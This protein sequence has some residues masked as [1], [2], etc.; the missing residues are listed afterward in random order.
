M[1]AVSGLGWQLIDASVLVQ[2]S[3]HQPSRSSREH[4]KPHFRNDSFS[5]TMEFAAR[6]LAL[7]S[8]VCCR[9]QDLDAGGSETPRGAPALSQ[10]TAFAA[11]SGDSGTR[12][13][14]RMGGGLWWLLAVPIVLL[15]VL[16]AGVRKFCVSLI[17]LLMIVL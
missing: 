8:L 15:T 12:R 17:V 2:A 3:Q 14:W 7:R 10:L 5:K 4:S 6:C 13:P 11:G 1:P 9:T 16:F